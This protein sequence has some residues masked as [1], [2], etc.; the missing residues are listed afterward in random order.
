MRGIRGTLPLL[1]AACAAFAVR[2]SGLTPAEF[3]QAWGLRRRERGLLLRP[4]EPDDPDHLVSREPLRSGGGGPRSAVN[5]LSP[6]EKKWCWRKR[7]VVHAE[8]RARGQQGGC[9][10]HGPLRCRRSV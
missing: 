4:R 5:G 1:L 3:S 2:A 6:F 7:R 8:G 9:L 10:A